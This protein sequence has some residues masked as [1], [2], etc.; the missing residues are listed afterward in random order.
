MLFVRRIIRA[1]IFQNINRTHY[2]DQLIMMLRGL[3]HEQ[4]FLFSALDQEVS[5]GYI[6]YRRDWSDDAEGH[7]R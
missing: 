1:S 7:P 5:R 4:A 2:D 3:N 6:D